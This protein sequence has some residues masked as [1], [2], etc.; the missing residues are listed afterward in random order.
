MSVMWVAEKATI[1][2][3][4]GMCNSTM[5]LME[6]ANPY[7]SQHWTKR[8]TK[9]TPSFLRK[10]LSANARQRGAMCA[11]KIVPT[12]N[13]QKRSSEKQRALESLRKR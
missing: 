2:T 11:K 7:S 9:A 6:E 3:R 8:M 5:K 4:A 10:A 13:S 12:C 1:H